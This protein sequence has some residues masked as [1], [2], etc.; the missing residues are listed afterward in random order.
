MQIKNIILCTLLFLGSLNLLAQVK[1]IPTDA[2]TIP[3]KFA[4][5]DMGAKEIVSSPLLISNDNLYIVEKI[6]LPYA[7]TPTVGL[8]N[9]ATQTITN[10]TIHPDTKLPASF[11]PVIT[12]AW[13]Q[14]MPIA[15]VQFPKYIL[16]NG[17]VKMLSAYNTDVKYGIE[18]KK[19]R[20][21]RTYATNSILASG[22]WNKV[23]I[24]QTGVYKIDYDFVKNQLGV[25]PENI[26]TSLIKVCGNGG[27]M[28]PEANSI[29][30][31]D[32]VQQTAI[33]T[34]GMED[35][36]WNANDYILFYAQGPHSIVANSNQKS[37][38]HLYN[39][40]N[41]RAYYFINFDANIPGERITAQAPIAATPNTIH[42]TF[43]DYVWHEKDSVNLGSTGKYWWGD[44]VG[45]KLGY[46][47]SNQFQFSIPNLDDSKPV[48][49][50]SHI[51]QTASSAIANFT[52]NVSILDANNTPTVQNT[53]S[54]S[55]S[56]VG[57][58]LYSPFA[59]D[60]TDTFSISGKGNTLDI[61]M[62]YTCSEDQA[63][64]YVDYIGVN[65]V[66]KLILGNG[67]MPFR[68]WEG[69]APGAIAQYNITAN[70]QPNIWDVTNPQKPIIMPVSSS[71]GTFS[72]VQNASTLHE[73]IA[74]NGTQF[75]TPQFIEGIPNQNL[76]N[77]AQADYII[78]THPNFLS[79]A[80]AMADLHAQKE[81]LSY[82][83]ATTNQIFNEFGSGSQDI[84]AMRNFIKMYYDKAST[85]AQLPKYVL[86]IGDASYDYKDR[87]KDNT[88][89][90]PSRESNESLD[91]TEAYVSDD[92]FAILDDVEDINTP[93]IVNTLDVGVGRFVCGTLDEANTLVQKC[94][95]YYSSETHGNW[96]LNQT[97]CADDQ[98][99]AYHVLDAEIMAKE[100]ATQQPNFNLYKI[101][102]DAFPIFNTP[103]GPRAPQAK[104]AMDAQ[105]FNGSLFVNY[106]GH[107]GT[108][109]WS[110][111]RIL[112]TADING[113]NNSLKMPIFITATCDFAPFDLPANKTCGELL[114]LYPKGGAIALLTT[115]AVVYQ[116]QNQIMNRDYWKDGFRKMDN[117]KMPALGDAL[118]LSKN[119]T[120]ITPSVFDIYTNFRKFVL[121]G[122]PA[123]MPAF[124]KDTVILDSVNGV[125]L[126][127]AID[128]LKAL[129]AY[130]LSGHV[131]DASN[132]S[133]LSNFNGTVSV[134][135]F[136]KPKKLSTLQ[137]VPNSYKVNYS[138]QNAVVFKG[139]ATVTNGKWKIYFLVPKDIDYS[140]GSA[141]ISMYATNGVTDAAGAELSMVKIGGSS[142]ATITDNIG[143]E[144]KPFMNNNK[145]INGGITSPNSTLYVELSDENGINTT[146]TSVGHDLIAY[147]DGN[148]SEPVVLNNFYEGTKDDYKSGV[149]RYPYKNLAEGKHT[150]TVRAWDALNNSNTATV[151]FV[152]TNTGTA[153][154]DRLFNFPNPFTTNTSF[155]FEH[156][157]PNE[158]LYVTIQIFSISG[159]V[160]KTIQQYVHSEGS[161]VN[162]ISWDGRDQMG[163]KLG[164]G[165]YLYRV[166]YKTL[167][168]KSTS[169]YE[170]LVIL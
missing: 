134:T 136:D 101:Y 38:S 22:K 12:L 106:N 110:E 107:G 112:N 60:K 119:R 131:A 139:N 92:F 56:N 141:K 72:V 40:Y 26:N 123:L 28:L 70:S 29:I 81:N 23:A 145:F 109:G 151:D 57:L 3:V 163:D 66:R 166:Y 105:I 19:T 91:K 54:T 98:D 10:Y 87:V 53:F 2:N 97:F 154:I 64:G 100:A 42:S 153:L 170:K 65:A 159:Q 133:L 137:N 113:Y 128:T 96:R 143:P 33:Q 25:T 84:S 125:A 43:N 168:G 140:I 79:Q 138:L 103:A 86:L 6:K 116:Y 80:Q 169:K 35:G 148:T 75:F 63:L 7:N 67:Q 114:Y 36:K 48:I 78:I 15:Y 68:S 31:L 4:N 162:D 59:K 99:Y 120:Y 122:D 144:I 126:N 121:L 161:R 94:R 158:P 18:V 13:E 167:T 85:A 150:I 49:I 74:L 124:P 156:N 157:F 142:N 152:V 11:E 14:K 164:R 32:D 27:G 129:N 165:V 69:V 90:V 50:T 51:A 16:Q 93:T 117:G 20:G 132:G 89:L 130:T 73:F 76:H 21:I 155:T 160:V 45:N 127:G 135:V 82:V 9:R 24:S 118:R 83:I 77:S 39:L 44:V 146:G 88:N 30:P 47:L 17:V 46:P 41:E 115:T 55:V 37:F 108:V 61:K 111:E 104:Q 147:L 102:V 149:V 52:F 71:A 95:T 58:S 5:T 34:F 1:D 8:T 62:K